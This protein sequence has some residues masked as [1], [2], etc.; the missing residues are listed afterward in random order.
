MNTMKNKQLLAVISATVLSI[1]AFAAFSNAK[2]LGANAYAVFNG[3][4]AG[5][6]SAETDRSVAWYVANI[7]AAKEQNKQCYDNPAIRTTPNCA[8]SLHALQISFVG[9]N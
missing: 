4:G 8:N 7:A 9:N 2:G 3:K 6:A 5:A 1:G